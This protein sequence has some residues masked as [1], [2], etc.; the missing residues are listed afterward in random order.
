VLADLVGWVSG[1]RRHCTRV[2]LV[3]VHHQLVRIFGMV[4]E[5]VVLTGIYHSNSFITQ[6]TDFSG[7][8]DMDMVPPNLS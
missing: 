6:A 2:E 8:N 1:H 5:Y 4:E 3:G 7:H